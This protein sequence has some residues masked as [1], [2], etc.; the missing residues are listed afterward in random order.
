MPVNEA[1]L[2]RASVFWWIG[3]LCLFGRASI[4]GL[5]QTPHT[6]LV[7]ALL[8]L[9]TALHWVMLYRRLPAR[10]RLAYFG[11][12]GA[13]VFGMGRLTPYITLPLGLFAILTAQALGYDLKLWQRGAFIGAYIGLMTLLLRSVEEIEPTMFA[14]LILGM[15]AFF[16]MVGAVVT[17]YQRQVQA[18]DQAEAAVAELK[19]AHD[20]LQAYAERVEDLTLMGERQRMAREL[21]DTLAQGLAGLILQLEA[22]Q[23]HLVNGR[24]GRAQEIVQ[25][26]MVRA[27]TTLADSRRTIDHLRSD[28][29]ADDFGA[30]LRAEAAHFT[31][32]TALAC[33]LELGDLPPLPESVQD[34]ALRAV[35]ES[36]TNVTRHAQATQVWIRVAHDDEALTL[37]IQDD[38][39]GFDPSA[40]PQRGHYGLLGL[41]ERAQLTGGVFDITSAPGAG[42][43]VRLRLPLA[44]ERT[45]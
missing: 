44:V 20:Q 10:W 17:L 24:A 38:G 13:L 26:A 33:R 19:Q 41:N 6:A 28:A 12:Q 11:I 8:G 14:P 9:H 31:A 4:P 21:H 15:F 39:I 18:R 43:S 5:F 27:R 30:A 45:A 36:L 29:P 32:A 16:L 1:R 2:V 42:T 23:A 7:I 3:L 25:H 34:H 35:S 37:E 40:P 22:V